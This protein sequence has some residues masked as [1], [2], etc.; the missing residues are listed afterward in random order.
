MD[1]GK[2]HLGDRRLMPYRR[3]PRG[4]TTLSLVVALFALTVLSLLVLTAPAGA[5]EEPKGY[6]ELARFGETGTEAG[7]LSERGTRAIGVD[8]E[9]G[10]TVSVLDAQQE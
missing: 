7:Q 6:G 9:H 10:T 8:G 4:I 2:H 1:T 5:V 3:L